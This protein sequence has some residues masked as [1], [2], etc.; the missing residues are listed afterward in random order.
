MRSRKELLAKRREV[1]KAIS[2]CMAIGNSKMT[3][4]GIKIGLLIGLP[5][6]LGQKNL[7]DWILNKPTVKQLKAEAMMKKDKKRKNNGRA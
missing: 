5:G 7:L 6:L 4:P 2:Q 3:V 1:K